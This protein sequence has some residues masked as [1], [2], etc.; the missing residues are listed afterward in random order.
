MC[1][2][3]NYEF[4]D[5]MIGPDIESRETEEQNDRMTA[6]VL[7]HHLISDDLI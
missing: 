2:K 4:D 5:S 6:T 3:R 7:L 1:R